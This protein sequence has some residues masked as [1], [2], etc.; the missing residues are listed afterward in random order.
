M[1]SWSTLE[2][3]SFVDTFIT[4]M[5]VRSITL[6]DLGSIREKIEEGRDL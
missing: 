4:G 5:A 2:R 1:S 3:L 6:M